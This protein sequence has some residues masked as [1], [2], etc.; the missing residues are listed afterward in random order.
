MRQVLDHDVDVMDADGIDELLVL[1]DEID[2]HGVRSLDR[3]R[4]VS[5]VDVQAIAPHSR[6]R[7]HLEHPVRLAYLA[8]RHLLAVPVDPIFVVMHQLMEHDSKLAPP[9]LARL[10]LRGDVVGHVD[11]DVRALLA[12]R[13]LVRELVRE[14]ERNGVAAVEAGPD[15]ERLVLVGQD[16]GVGRQ[17][18]AVGV[19][20]VVRIPVRGRIVAVVHD[21]LHSGVIGIDRRR[22][23]RQPCLVGADGVHARDDG[24]AVPFGHLD[25]LAQPG[26]LAGEVPADRHGDN[27]VHQSL[28]DPR[29][30]VLPH[31][32]VAFHAG[33]HA[34]D[35]PLAAPLRLRGRV[36]R[37]AD[38]PHPLG[39]R[40]RV[41][42][43]LAAGDQRHVGVEVQVDAVRRIVGH[44]L[45]DDCQPVLANL[46]YGV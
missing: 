16:I 27:R 34:N 10:I 12:C 46:R 1:G 25:Q 28:A 21:A 33:G 37:S 35:Y 29:L 41:L 11:R 8:L 4:D 36:C 22:P 23:M 32:L 31:L 45:P 20:G 40:L 14:A 30:N 18:H 9:Q 39:N 3:Q 6:A 19:L 42:L 5:Q 7:T 17:P 24:H 43:H 44:Q 13:K 2:A 26:R 38:I 15:V